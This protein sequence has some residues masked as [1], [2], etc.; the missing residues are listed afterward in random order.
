MIVGGATRS[1]RGET[2][3]GDA[4][5][6]RRIDTVE[7]VALVDGLGH[8]REAA[9]AAEAALASFATTDRAGPDR[10]LCRMDEAIRTTRGAAVVVASIEPATRRLVV[11]G[12][13]N[14]RAA[15][16]GR[17]RVH[18]ESVPGI[19]GTG[20]RT[21]RPLELHWTDRDLLVLWSDGVAAGLDVD[22]SLLRLKHQPDAVARRLLDEF[23]T[24]TDDAAVVCTLLGG[25]S[26]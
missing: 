9:A 2:W 17:R 10:I 24:G 14:V 22:R 21:P 13:G 8:G 7:Q 20:I 11:A 5:A 15:L 6:C 4:W 23:A 16:F 3:C 25:T 1:F 12:I 19:V 18:I 26:S